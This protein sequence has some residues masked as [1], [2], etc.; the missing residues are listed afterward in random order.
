MRRWTAFLLLF[1][2]STTILMAAELQPQAPRPRRIAL[3]ELEGPS[4]IQ[5]RS[6]NLE[7]DATEAISAVLRQK[8][9]EVIPPKEVEQAIKDFGFRLPLKKGEMQILGKNLRVDRVAS[10]KITEVIPA[11]KPRQNSVM[12]QLS[13]VDPVTGD[14]VNTGLSMFRLLPAVRGNSDV[15]QLKEAIQQADYYAQTFIS[16][17]SMPIAKV[18]V[19]DIPDEVIVNRGSRDGLRIGDEAF[20]IRGGER[21]NFFRLYKV[22]YAQS[23]V[24]FP[25]GGRR[26]RPGHPDQAV[27]RPK[28]P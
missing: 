19:G 22:G 25:E 12:I 15:E 26:P 16:S 6:R 8:G 11:V 13:V 2:L 24:S 3:L 5:F 4:E 1:L 28:R 10:G 17:I 20:L 21:L 14:F 23:W 7:R 9:N 18:T 27:F